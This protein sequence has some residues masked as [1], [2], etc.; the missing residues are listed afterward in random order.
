VWLGQAAPPQVAGRDQE[1]PIRGRGTDTRPI[2]RAR[3]RGATAG[4]L[5]RP[6]RTLVIPCRAAPPPGL[7]SAGAQD[8]PDAG[9]WA[10]HHVRPRPDGPRVRVQLD[11]KGFIRSLEVLDQVAG[12]ASRDRTSIRL[13]VLQS[14]AAFAVGK[15][16]AGVEVSS[17]DVFKIAE[18]WE[19]WVLEGPP[20]A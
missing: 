15:A 11:A 9:L 12:A 16:V 7:G 1:K 10:Q 14:A 13:S 2:V 6:S 5:T 18:A 8:H 20:M 4:R 3:R 17:A 19:R